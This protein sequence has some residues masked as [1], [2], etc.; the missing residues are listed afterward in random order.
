MEYL[1]DL[2]ERLGKALRITS[3]SEAPAASASTNH[4]GPVQGP[5]A[6]S[7]MNLQ[8]L[9]DRLILEV[10]EEEEATASGIVLPDTAKEKPQRGRVLAVGPGAATSSRRAHRTGR[11]RG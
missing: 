9:A 3:P 2:I 11:R 8:P 4:L 1:K 10:L 5:A 7:A 6:G